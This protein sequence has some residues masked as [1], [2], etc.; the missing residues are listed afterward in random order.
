MVGKGREERGA[1]GQ[2]A[3]TPRPDPQDACKVGAVDIGDFGRAIAVEV[4]DTHGRE[5]AEGFADVG[6][7]GDNYLSSSSVLK[8]SP[9]VRP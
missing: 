4:R 9:R 5:P 8:K 6:G 3:R 2:T 7:R 1:F